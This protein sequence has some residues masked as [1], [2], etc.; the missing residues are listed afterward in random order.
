MFGKLSVKGNN[1]VEYCATPQ[2]LQY[3]I[4]GHIQYIYSRASNKHQANS[5]ILLTLLLCLHDDGI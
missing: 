1:L 3:H 4:A 2:E 5:M